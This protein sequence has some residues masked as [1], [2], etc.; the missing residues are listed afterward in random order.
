MLFNS[1]PFIFVFLPITL[2]GYYL[3]IRAGLARWIFVFLVVA[4]LLFY[5]VWNPP[6][7]FL[8]LISMGGNYIFGSWLDARREKGS[9]LAWPTGLGIAFNLAILFY[10]KYANFFI[11]NL[12]LVAGT[13]YNLERIILP[14]AISFYTLQQIAFLVDV[15]RGEI[16]P[17]GIWRYATFVIFFPQLIAGPIVHYKEM[18]PQ[19]FGRQLGR[20][21]TANLTIGLT[22]FAIGL[23]KKTVLA[24]SA[25]LYASPLYDAAQ[26]GAVI[27]LLAAWKAAICYTLQLYFD[28]SG[29]SDMA[30]GLAR[31]FGIKLPPNFHSPLRAASIIDYWRRWHMTL[32]QFIVAYMY[33]PLVIPL[34][35]WGAAKGFGKWQMFTLTTAAPTIVLFLVIGFWHGAAWT[36]V[37][38]GGMHGIYLSINEWWRMLKR[39]ARKKAKPGIPD[40]VFYHALTLLCVVV[41]NVVFRAESVE[42]ATR[43]WA[44]MVR[45]GELAQ[46]LAILPTHAAE[47][48]IEPFAF[49]VFCAALIAFFPNT[50]QIMGRYSPILNWDKWRGVAL[51][52]MRMEWRLTVSWAVFMGV[53]LFLGVAFVSR[54]Q[55]E[56]IYFNF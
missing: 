6:Y 31:M 44:G 42:A 16:R 9:A 26:A 18:M 41:A 20:F 46:L 33:Q 40:M 25:A 45:F 55:S 32:Q 4:S 39:K 3:L 1:L 21:A 34:T 30:L 2:L 23:F 24:D 56:F 17:S 29:Y 12:N 13:S 22:I 10:F 51:A 8:L 27:G 5:T 7:L 52:P 19:F 15:V 11:D 50:Q 36:F 37:I 38:F 54:G 28:F 47:L 35:R 49:I 43:I 48:I 53:V 14:L